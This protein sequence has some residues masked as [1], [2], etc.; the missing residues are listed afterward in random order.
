M[1]KKFIALIF[2]YPSALYCVRIGVDVDMLKTTVY[3]KYYENRTSKLTVKLNKLVD[4]ITVL[5]DKITNLEHGVHTLDMIIKIMSKKFSCD[6]ADFCLM[7]MF[8]LAGLQER[9]NVNDQGVARLKQGWWVIHK[10]I[11]RK[12]CLI[13]DEG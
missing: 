8:V 6:D 3:K 11:F 2:L 1:N 13:N 10:K 7:Y 5:E 9:K 4:A 12:R